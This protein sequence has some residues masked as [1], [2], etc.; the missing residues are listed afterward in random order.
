[1]PA[2]AGALAGGARDKARAP[3]TGRACYLISGILPAQVLLKA[4][5]MVV[6]MLS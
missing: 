5:S 6:L 2:V 3:S 4:G 1:M